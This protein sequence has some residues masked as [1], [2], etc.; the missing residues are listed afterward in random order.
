[1]NE[2]FESPVTGESAQSIRKAVNVR[3]HGGPS[4]EGTRQRHHAPVLTAKTGGG[5]GG[6]G[7]RPPAG[8]LDARLAPRGYVKRF[9]HFGETLSVS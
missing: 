1:M 3:G 8:A 2:R 9:S 5:G 4:A 7:Y 6:G